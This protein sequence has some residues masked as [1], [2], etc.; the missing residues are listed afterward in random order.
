MR[1]F[2]QRL[3]LLSWLSIAGLTVLS[4]QSKSDWKAWNK[5]KP[6]FS[7]Q[8]DMLFSLDDKASG[9][10]SWMGNSYIT[11]TLRNNY[12]ELGLRYE[13]LLRPMPGHERTGTRHTAPTPQGVH[14]QVW[15]GDAG[16]LLRSVWLWHPLP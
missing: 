12:L 9:Y 10:E 2:V 5:F 13:D 15:R 1:H 16:R 11:G 4:A 7:V 3:C 8:S 14:W 6:S